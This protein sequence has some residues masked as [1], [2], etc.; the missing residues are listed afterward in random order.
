MSIRIDRR[1]FLAALSCYW[2][3]RPV[4]ADDEQIGEDDG[5][6]WLTI[7]GSDEDKAKTRIVI[8]RVTPVAGGWTEFQVK[9][10]DG[11]K[12][13]IEADNPSAS[14]K[15]KD[16]NGNQT[17]RVNQ[18]GD[19]A[20]HNRVRVKLP[21][22]EYHVF[23]DNP[24][25]LGDWTPGTLTVGGKFVVRKASEGK[26][27]KIKLDVSAGIVAIKPQDQPPPHK[28][29]EGGNEPIPGRDRGEVSRD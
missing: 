11:T 3:V 18:T 9:D 1:I 29:A 5:E 6:V 2:V 15:P 23:I 26:P 19:D 27:T 4:L 17:G 25:F 10:L 24:K 12:I 28:G 22:G 16:D 20:T 13:S 8:W 14:V 7:G 21:P